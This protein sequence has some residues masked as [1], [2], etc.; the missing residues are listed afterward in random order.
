[1][2][3]Y[4]R[5]ARIVGA[6]FIIAIVTS[7]VGG[8]MIDSVLAVPDVLSNVSANETS[9]LIGVFLELVNG[10]A[11]IGIVTGL[12]PILRQQNEAQ[13]LGYVGLRII[14]VAI[15]VVAVVPPLT[16]LAFSQELPAA[17]AADA[18]LL[19]TIGASFVAARGRLLG[20]LLGIFFG[21]AGL[22]LYTLLYQ[23]RLV[24]RFISLWGLAAVVLLL[25]WN[26][27]ELFGV[28]VSAGIV[29]GL[30]IILNELF[31]G[32]WLIVRGFDSSAALSLSGDK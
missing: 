28:H 29:F 20:Q 17:G 13:A 24:P 11:V 25:A 22:L 14:E 2:N 32:I 9:L 6:L 4:K 5:T 23:T 26:L 8:V 12:F 16:L 27:L 10:I 3:T 7:I 19:G 30:P 31:L 1:M 18:S 21:L 15:I